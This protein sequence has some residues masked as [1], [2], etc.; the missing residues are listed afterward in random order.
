MISYSFNINP[1]DHPHTLGEIL[2]NLFFDKRNKKDIAG[3]THILIN[4]DNILLENRDK[5]VKFYDKNLQKEIICI[6]TWLGYDPIE[7]YCGFGYLKLKFKFKD[8]T[9]LENKDSKK[10]N[11][12]RFIK[13]A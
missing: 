8:N 1:K 9:Y 5:L 3:Y 11:C 2:R 13:N 7:I 10:D 4:K 12:W 6:S